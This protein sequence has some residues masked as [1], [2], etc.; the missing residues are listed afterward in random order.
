[1]EYAMIDPS[2]AD[3]YARD[4]GDDEEERDFEDVTESELDDYDEDGA[5]VDDGEDD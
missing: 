4:D 5:E 1:M 2:E 3:Y